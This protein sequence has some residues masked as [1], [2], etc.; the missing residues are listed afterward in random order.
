M[1]RLDSYFVFMIKIG[2]IVQ[3]VEWTRPGWYDDKIV[4]AGD[5]DPGSLLRRRRRDIALLPI[6][7]MNQPRR[8]VADPARLPYGIPTPSR[9]KRLIIINFH[10]NQ[11]SGE[12][13]VKESTLVLALLGPDNQ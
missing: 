7:Y 12:K 5:A 8:R 2:E 4:R 13:K 3:H 11:A 9:T 6:L 1:T 10:P